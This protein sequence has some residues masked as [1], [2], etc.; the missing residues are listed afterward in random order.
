M[1]TPQ[2]SVK[3]ILECIGAPET[4]SGLKY[5]T[6]QLKLTTGEPHITIGRASK[7]TSKNIQPNSNN[8]FFDCAVM[9]RN[10]AEIYLKDSI[11]VRHIPV[12]RV[13]ESADISAG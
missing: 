3:V 1:T 9:S 11:K 4:V 5:P 7:N 12:A 13:Q 10:H 8:A 2:D 6:R